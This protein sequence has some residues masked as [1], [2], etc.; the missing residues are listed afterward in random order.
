MTLGLLLQL[1]AGAMALTGYAIGWWFEPKRRARRALT[2]IQEARLAD[3]RDGDR[4][5]VTGIARA[6]VETTTSPIGQRSCIGFHVVVEEKTSSGAGA[7]WHTLLVRSHCLPFGLVDGDAEAVVE[8]PFDLGLDPDD[9]GDVWSNLPPTLFAML[10][11][12]RI[13]LTGHFGRD[14]EFRFR[15]ALLRAGDRV[16]VLGRVSVEPHPY[17]HRENP[18]G[19][20]LQC[21]V[22]GSEAQP[23]MIGDVDDLSLN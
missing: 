13:P 9:R 17:G 8:G 21:R 11:E 23:V 6:R 1:G 10:E 15:E 12:A 16:S 3:L 2:R 20:P 18:R 22:S 7:N 4:L 19:T 5:R 14:K